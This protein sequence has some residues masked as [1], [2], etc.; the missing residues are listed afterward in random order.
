MAEG[1]DYENP[2]YCPVYQRI[3]SIDLCFDSLMALG[4]QVKVSSVKELA[5][6]KNIEE[7]RKICAACPYSKL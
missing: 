2:H 6:V 4:R 7:A 5:V 3:I 1:L